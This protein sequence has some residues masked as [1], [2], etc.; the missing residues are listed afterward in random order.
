MTRRAGI[1]F[2]DTSHLPHQRVVSGA[3][4]L[5]AIFAQAQSAMYVEEEEKKET[6]MKNGYTTIILI[7]SQWPPIAATHK[8]THTHSYIVPHT[9][10]PAIHSRK[11]SRESNLI[12]Y[13][14]AYF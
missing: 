4:H 10:A 6:S 7:E 14:D 2:E 9:D 1:A 5:N 12:L 11:H 3:Q 13:F 8:H